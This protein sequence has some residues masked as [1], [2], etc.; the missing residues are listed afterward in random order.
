[1]GRHVVIRH[2]HIEVLET[3]TAPALLVVARLIRYHHAGLKRLVTPAW[4]QTLW[5]FMDVEKGADA[6]AGAVPIVETG[7][8]HVGPRQGIQHHP[9]RAFRE[10]LPGQGDVTAQ[11]ERVQVTLTLRGRAD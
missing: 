9:A 5:P 4:P 1:M 8:P 6:M 10:F 3:D 2:Y 11:H 7:V